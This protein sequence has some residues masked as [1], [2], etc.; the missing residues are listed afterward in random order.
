MGAALRKALRPPVAVDN[1]QS[2]QEEA[3]RIHNSLQ[4][5]LRQSVFIKKERRQQ[6]VLLRSQWFRIYSLLHCLSKNTE[7]GYI[8]LSSNIQYEWLL[9]MKS[10]MNYLLQEIDP[11]NLTTIGEVNEDFA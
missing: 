8:S 4:Q 3:E 5:V 6:L 11:P 7:D 2:L 9:S 10:K 1:W